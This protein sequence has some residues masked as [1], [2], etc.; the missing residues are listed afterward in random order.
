M[1]A[2]LRREQLLPSDTIQSVKEGTQAVS[3]AMRRKDCT[4]AVAECRRVLEIDPENY[5]ALANL[6]GCQCE[7]GDYE[8]SLETSAKALGRFPGAWIPKFNVACAYERLGETAT[9]LDWLDAALDGAQSTEPAMLKLL[10]DEAMKHFR[11]CPDPVRYAKIMARCSG[12]PATRDGASGADYF[13]ILAKGEKREY[14]V[15]LPSGTGKMMMRGDGDEVIK[16]RTYAKVVT[17]FS[18]VPGAESQAEYFRTD[19]EGVHALNGKSKDG[20]EYLDTPLP[21]Q[22]GTSWVTKSPGGTKRSKVESFES[23][24]LYD[25][26]Y[27]NC[28]KVSARSNRPDGTAFTEVGEVSYYAS[29]VGLVK[30]TMRVMGAPIEFELTTP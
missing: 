6:S 23:V 1:E 2:E 24:E 12:A 21:L 5:S 8:A 9:A 17:V 28:V 3:V 13:H 26:K 25:R 29:G 10:P 22:V 16:G 18:G 14:V 15:R 4:A 20:P 19:S 11:G 7:L 30:S 27:E